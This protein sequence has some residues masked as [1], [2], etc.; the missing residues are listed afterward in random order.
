MDDNGD[1][2][3]SD[4]CFLH[5]SIQLLSIPPPSTEPKDPYLLCISG[6]SVGQSISMKVHILF[7]YL[8]SQLG[9]IEDV[10]LASHIGR[11]V[12]L[13]NSVNLP[14]EPF[15]RIRQD[16]NELNSAMSCVGNLDLLL[17]QV[18][19]SFSYSNE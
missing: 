7:E 11:I 17:S 15:Q 10:K 4:T 6:L 9:F 3:V 8:A 14:R 18:Y 2:E 5:D 19:H 16:T 1:F 13:G 12:F